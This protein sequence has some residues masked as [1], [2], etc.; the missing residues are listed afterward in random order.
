[1]SYTPAL[2]AAVT[3]ALASGPQARET[4]TERMILITRQAF[5]VTIVANGRDVT[6]TQPVVSVK[7]N[8]DGSGTR[9]LRNGQTVN[10]SWRFINPRQT[11]IEVTGPEGV[12]RWVIIELNERIYR[13]ANMDTGVEFIHVPRGSLP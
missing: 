5:D 4:T 2:F 10:G 6:A 11:Q 12:S 8:A 9:T 13:K 7:Y 1:M 3:A